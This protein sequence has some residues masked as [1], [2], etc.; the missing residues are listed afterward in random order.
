MV[1]DMFFSTP[2][3]QRNKNY[4]KISVGGVGVFA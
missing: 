4:K 1:K 2:N 3:M